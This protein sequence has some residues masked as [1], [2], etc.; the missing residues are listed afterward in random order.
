VSK[1]TQAGDF[2]E[3]AGLFFKGGHGGKRSHRPQPRKSRRRNTGCFWIVIT[4]LGLTQ[5]R[6]S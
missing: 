1:I 4:I 2:S 3:P 5:K 6:P